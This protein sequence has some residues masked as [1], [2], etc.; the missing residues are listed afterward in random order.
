MVCSKNQQKPTTSSHS[1]N[2]ACH[3]SPFNSF[4][5]AAS[6]CPSAA[7]MAAAGPKKGV[8]RQVRAKS[9]QGQVMMRYRKRA[10][11]STH[12]SSGRANGAWYHAPNPMTLARSSAFVAYF[13]GR[14]TRL[15]ST[16]LL[17]H[18]WRRITLANQLNSYHGATRRWMVTCRIAFQR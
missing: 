15:S 3:P 11:V 10:K 18:A 9:L 4:N 17:N 6:R 5:L 1:H 8:R 14:C 16:A 13:E 2:K 7:Q 12:E